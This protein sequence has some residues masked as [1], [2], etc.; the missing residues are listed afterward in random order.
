[1][2][3]YSIHPDRDNNKISVM[4]D[5]FKLQKISDFDASEKKQITGTHLASGGLTMMGTI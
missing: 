1:M 4:P 2:I 3:V 5:N